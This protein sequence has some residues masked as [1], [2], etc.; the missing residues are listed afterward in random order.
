MS[1]FM[2]VDRMGQELDLAQLQKNRPGGGG[3]VLLKGQPDQEIGATGF[4]PATPTTPKWCATKLRYAPAEGSYHNALRRFSR[5][6]S[7]AVSR[8]RL[9]LA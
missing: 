5:R 6:I 9:S 4:E 7:T 3:L 1:L 2:S 8:S